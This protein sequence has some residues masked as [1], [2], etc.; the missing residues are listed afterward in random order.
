MKNEHIH[1]PGDGRP[2]NRDVYVNGRLVKNCKYADTKK[3]IADVYR[4]PLRTDKYRKR[5]L[6]KRLHGTIEVRTRAE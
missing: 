1:F 3:G 5:V 2:L 6:T 4:F